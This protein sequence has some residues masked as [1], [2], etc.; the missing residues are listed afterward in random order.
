[1]AGKE[2]ADKKKTYIEGYMQIIKRY[3]GEYLVAQTAGHR[4]LW[5]AGV[6]T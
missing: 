6:C 4:S 2:T 3:Y 5:V 1:M